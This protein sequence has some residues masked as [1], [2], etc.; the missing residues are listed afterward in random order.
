M[1]KFLAM[2]L[3]LVMV[4][5]MTVVAAF[6]QDTETDDEPEDLDAPTVD[7]PAEEEPTVDAPA[8]DTPAATPAQPDNNPKT[9]VAL[10]VV[11]AMIAAAA[12]VVTKKH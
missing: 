6:A 3:A 1:K 8:V 9:G 10:A 4:F 5:S 12:A 11:P 7:A 2:L